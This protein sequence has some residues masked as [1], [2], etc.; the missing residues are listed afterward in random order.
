MAL[1][2]A[3]AGLDKSHLGATIAGAEVPQEEEVSKQACSFTSPHVRQVRIL[4][5][6]FL[7]VAGCMSRAC[8][9]SGEPVSSLVSNPVSKSC[10]RRGLKPSTG[11]S[12]QICLKP[13]QITQ[14]LSL[15]LEVL[16]W[17]QDGVGLQR[18]ALPESV[19]QDNDSQDSI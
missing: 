18:G 11:L 12:V 9:N 17:K 1:R 8:C 2:P 7:T 14:K 15:A 10:M 4:R 3:A 13:I 6:D 16:F 19:D 5:C